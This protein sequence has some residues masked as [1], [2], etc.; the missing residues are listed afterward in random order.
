MFQII[1]IIEALL[2]TTIAISMMNQTFIEKTASYIFEKHELAQLEHLCVVLPTRRAVYF[3]KRALALCADKPFLAPEVVA[4]DDWV[5]QQS[6]VEVADNVT[7]L[8]ELFETFKE[9]DPLITFERFL[10]WGSVLLRDFDQ[11]DQYLIDPDYLFD[12]ITEAKALERW[13]V[14]WPN[15]NVKTDTQRVK[16]YFDLFANL[17]A[18]YHKFQDRLKAKKQAYRGMAYRMLADSPL[19]PGGGFLVP[20]SGARGLWLYFIGF[21]ALS[22][23]E[24]T[25][26]RALV[27]TKRAELL[28]DTDYYYMRDNAYMEGGKLLRRYKEAGW[29]GEWK[30]VENHYAE[31]PKE[32]HTY[33]VPNASMQAK[34][35]G[36]LYRRWC[37]DGHGGSDARPV[38]M[39]LADENL[40]VPMLNGL[41]EDI[42][43]LNITMG[44]TLRNSLLFTLIDS[45]FELQMTI[46]EFRAKDGRDIKIPKYNHRTV[47][48]VLN[49][50]F[51]RRY[52]FLELQS[53]S[54]DTPTIIQ[55][56]IREI[57]QRNF[58]YLDPSQLLEWG[59]NHP[60]FK[61][62][63]KRWDDKPQ[64]IINALFE[65]IDLLRTVYRDT[66]NAIE[67]EYLYLFYTLLKQLETTLAKENVE[68]LNVKLFRSFLYELIRQ[69]RI[70]FSGEPLSPLQVMG[71]LETRALDFEKIIILS[72]NEGVFPTTKRQNSL[73][74][75]DI[76]REAGLPVYSDQDAV[77]SY[78]FYRLLQ[79]ASEVHLVY[80]TDPN[81]YNGGEKSRFIL[82]I[83]HELVP[84]YPDKISYQEHLVMFAEQ[85]SATSS[86]Q[87]SI[88]HSQFTHSPLDWSVPKTADTLAFI[89]KSLT[90]KGLFATHFNQ[91]LKCSLQYYFN[92]VA[93]VSEDEEVEE[94]MGAAEFGTWIHAV[95]ER[96]D[97]EFLME[98]KTI[99]E[100]Q[101]KEILAEEFKKQFGGYD[102]ESGINR[103]LY[104]VAQ[105]SV[106][107]FLKEQRERNENLEVLANERALSATVEVVL[108]DGILPVKIGGKIDRIELL[109]KTVR[110]ADYKTGKIES[111]NTVKP[112]LIETLLLESTKPNDEKIRQLWLYQ[113][114]VFKQMLLEK[115]LK[116]KGRE[117][118]LEEYEVSSG[119]YSLRNIKKGFIQN[120]LRFDETNDPV[121]YVE[122]S[123]K[124]IQAFVADKLLN[125][126]EPFQKTTNTDTCKYCDFREICGR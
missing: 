98:N 40:L 33:A 71:M 104:Q 82:Q 44:L 76:A 54:A 101:I 122:E 62:L 90:E 70:P 95:L 64:T 112:D 32:I 36:E 46:A 92:R 61:A 99:S 113:Y 78:H 111:L 5:A 13:R 81:T 9:I 89:K 8:F 3:F 75:F 28:W 23:S 26:L 68:K 34:V 2:Q 10:Q 35:A 39:V 123:E 56:T 109:D 63:F 85:Q 1:T 18:V 93:G 58:V 119:F 14:D 88:T 67:T 116:L 50:P 51:I 21:N 110:V 84:Q 25:I 17:R 87:D 52:E 60:L 57:Q 59:D 42:T 55:K 121:L 66:K 120:P 100:P 4:I 53:R 103:L 37:A 15:S 45:L 115:G 11:I 79:R 72:L 118:R 20:P 38:A 41:D 83:Q 19:A 77:M 91:Y 117:F 12:Y 30:W 7:L 102:P 114:L 108:P 97:V 24:E 31:T 94:R 43:D 74:P 16:G 29:T 47:Q 126:D 22:A 96:I 105:Q 6:A 107:D 49:H 106:L 73:I 27:K 48:K 80:V 125:P 65:L 124:Y 86:Q 69:T